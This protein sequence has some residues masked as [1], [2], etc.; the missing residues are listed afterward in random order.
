[1]KNVMS[2][3]FKPSGELIYYRL[4]VAGSIDFAA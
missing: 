1:M 3:G 2:K 4:R